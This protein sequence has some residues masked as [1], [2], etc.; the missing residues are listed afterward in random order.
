[1]RYLFYCFF[2][3]ITVSYSQSKSNLSEQEYTIF[4]NKIRL[5][6]SSNIDSAFIYTDKLET[7]NNHLHQAFAQGTKSY[8]YQI[9]GDV[10]N[11]KFSLDRA[12]E[13]LKKISSS[14]DKIEM[15]AYL[16]NCGGLSYWK[17]GD[18][19]HA[20][21]QFQEGRKLSISI[22][23]RVQALK[24]NINIGLINNEVGNYKEAISISK[25]SD[26]MIDKMRYLFSDEQFNM[27][28]SAI[29]L[30]LG[31]YYEDFYK[32]KIDKTEYLDSAQFYY[33]KAIIYSKS[34]DYNKMLAQMNLANIYYLKKNFSEAEKGYQSILNSSKENGFFLEYSKIIYNLGD[35]YYY[36]KEYKQSLVY[37]KKVDSIYYADKANP[38]EF[39]KSNY[40]QAKI[41]QALKNQEEAAKYSEIYLENYEKN[42]F[43]LNKEIAEVNFKKSKEQLKTEM[44]II[45][46]DYKYK[47]NL[48]ILVV[49]VLCVLVVFLGFLAVRG[50][51]KKKIAER[52][53]ADLIEEYRMNRIN[54]EKEIIINQ[55]IVKN[56]SSVISIEKE[57][58]ILEKLKFLEKKLEYLKPDFT[59]QSA[60]KKIKT[61]TSYLSS[62]VNNHYNK[63]FS[64]YLNELRIN[65]VIEEMISNATYRKYST[66]AIAESVGFK[67]AVS[68]TKSFNKRTG[69]TPIQFIK[70]LE[71]E[72]V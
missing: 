71:K 23:D 28:K 59:Q 64:E 54:S 63:T 27:Y 45:Q 3:M 29:N 13:S 51:K 53:V 37:F 39:L 17:R 34:L 56:T 8:L 36:K 67:N 10:Q 50:F 21:D 46:E 68:F 44:K 72:I 47:K 70:G 33:G 42:E 35:L 65:Y 40:Y 62:V 18:F 16:L 41:Y 58:E 24:F 20:L 69:V 5:L 49:L 43:K 25:Q 32:S 6:S 4:K 7:S 61:N 57:N 11:S 14:K 9:K 2:L 30:N 26:L 38:I 66:Q 22:N 12:Y 1:M 52:K 15:N 55:E 48:T 60:A 19:S 31:K